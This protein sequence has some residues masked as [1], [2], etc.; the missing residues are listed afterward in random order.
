MAQT[1]YEI[2]ITKVFHFLAPGG[3]T[4]GPKFIK[5]GED[6]ADTEVYHPPK[7]HHR[8]STHAGDIRY[9]TPADKETNKK[10]TVNDISTTCLSA[11]VDN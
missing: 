7:F 5:R 11:C 8:T 4:P 9:K 2:C 6:L 10:Q 3:L 1:V